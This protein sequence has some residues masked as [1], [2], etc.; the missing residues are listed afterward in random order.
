MEL[1]NL[2]QK[3]E[4]HHP[5]S[6]PSNKQKQQSDKNRPPLPPTTPT[7]NRSVAPEPKSTTAK[8]HLHSQAEFIHSD[9]TNA[10]SVN[11]L[12]STADSEPGSELHAARLRLRRSKGLN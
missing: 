5:T 1:I 4:N 9:N 7:A 11:G 6:P 2:L 8:V 12:S 10:D 3:A